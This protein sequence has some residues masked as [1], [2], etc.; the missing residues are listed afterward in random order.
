MNILSIDTSTKNFSLAVG[1]D[2]KVI[3]YRNVIL[4]RLLSSS[5]IPTMNNIL[6]KVDM[7]VQDIDGFAVGLGPGSFT[8]L[9]VGLATIKGLAFATNKPV[10]GVSS[11]D[12]LAMGVK[13]D[14][15]ICV[16]CDARRDLVYAALYTKKG[17]QLQRE[18]DYVLSDI[19][20]IL[21]K[22]K[23]E[24]ILIGDGIKVFEKDIRQAKQNQFIILAEEKLWKPQAKHLLLLTEERFKKR[25]FDNVDTLV[26]LYLYPEDCQVRK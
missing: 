6:K 13:R 14:G 7:N 8:G 24:T 5:I 12:V 2:G 11:L 1:I 4:G 9:R 10:I 21:K 15:N 3:R 16:V 23:V 20:S 19:Q 22:V 17:M 18:G 26:P 25:T